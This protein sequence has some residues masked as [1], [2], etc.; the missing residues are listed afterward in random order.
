ML[1]GWTVV[2]IGGSRTGRG[3][4]EYSFNGSCGSIISHCSLPG[5]RDSLDVV[6]MVVVGKK[7]Q[8]KAV[9]D[10]AAASQPTWRLCVL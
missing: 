7:G 5:R 6:V 8:T 2:V 3:I 9:S 1:D 4:L 10:S